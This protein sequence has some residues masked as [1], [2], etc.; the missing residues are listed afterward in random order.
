VTT[1]EA[2]RKLAKWKAGCSS[3]KTPSS[4]DNI[5]A[6][7]KYVRMVSRQTAAFVIQDCGN[8]PDDIARHGREQVHAL[9]ELLTEE[10]P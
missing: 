7:T 8:R 2:V 4:S 3:S 6:A 1:D 9:I 5:W 10:K